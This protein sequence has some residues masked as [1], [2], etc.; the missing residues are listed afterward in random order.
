MARL[1][2]NTG[3]L[4]TDWA[5]YTTH[6]SHK[7]NEALFEENGPPPHYTSTLGFQFGT[8]GLGPQA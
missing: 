1:Q 8:G 7:A 6:T 5:D 3:T 4:T 2:D